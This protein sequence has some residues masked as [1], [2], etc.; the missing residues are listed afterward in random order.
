MLVLRDDLPTGGRY[1]RGRYTELKRGFITA[2]SEFN[3]QHFDIPKQNQFWPVPSHCR[4][5]LGRP[6]WPS[7]TGCKSLMDV[8]IAGSEALKMGI[9]LLPLHPSE[10]TLVP[11]RRVAFWAITLVGKGPEG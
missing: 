9:V 1:A 2:Y 6:G 8:G 10:S 4:P 3:V 7:S 11:L 5:H